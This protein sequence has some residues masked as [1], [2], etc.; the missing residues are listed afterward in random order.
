[1][2]IALVGI[3]L[4]WWVDHNRPEL[5]EYDIRGPVSVTFSIRTSPNSKEGGVIKDIDGI[6]FHGATI[7]LH[8]ENGGR[9]FPTSSLIN[10][11]WQS[12]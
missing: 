11:H 4:A 7:V 12:E 10:F 5:E 9:V 1:M 6:D 8:K 2:V 3:S